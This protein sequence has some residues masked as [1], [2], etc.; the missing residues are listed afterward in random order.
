MN[1]RRRRTN[2]KKMILD[3]IEGLNHGSDRRTFTLPQLHTYIPEHWDVPHNYVDGVN[4]AGIRMLNRGE[5]RQ[6]DGCT[7]ELVK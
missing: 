1:Q 2:Y 6:I 4:L 7:F 3:S 5:I